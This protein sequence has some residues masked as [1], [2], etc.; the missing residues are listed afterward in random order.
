MSNL[1]E[2]LPLLLYLGFGGIYCFYGH[3]FFKTMLT[4]AGC[5]LGMGLAVLICNS[6]APKELPILV[7]AAVLGVIA[8]G[9]LFWLTY[10]TAVFAVGFFSGFL[11][12][13]PILSVL[14]IDPRGNAGIAIILLS[15]ICTGLLSLTVKESVMIAFTSIIGAFTMLMA[16]QLLIERD[17][18]FVAKDLADAH[19]EVTQRYWWL[20]I[21]LVIC[22]ILLQQ[23]RGDS[24]G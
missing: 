4:V 10:Q 6:L 20:L 1:M 16:L 15:G 8:G 2:I 18:Y 5:F 12:A 22:G 7:L 21:V 14:P 24:K 17:Y 3:Q 23:R 19:E 13:P 11:V 9:V